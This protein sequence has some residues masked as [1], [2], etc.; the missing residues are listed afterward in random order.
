MTG[1]GVEGYGACPVHCLQGLF[2]FK[3]GRAIF[4][5]DRQ[6]AVALRA[7]LFH[8]RGIEHGTVRGSGEWEGGRIFP[9]FALRI[10]MFVFG[11][12]LGGKSARQAAKRD[13]VLGIERQTVAIPLIAKR[14]VGRGLHRFLIHDG[15]AAL[16]VLHD[17]VECAFAVRDAFFGHAAQIDLAR[18]SSRLS[19]DHRGVFGRVTEDVDAL[20]GSVE[21]DAVGLGA[22][23]VDR[24][25]QLQRLGVE[26][27]GGLAAGEAVSGFGIDHRSIAA[28]AGDL[29]N[30]REGIEVEHG[31]A[32][33][34]GMAA[35]APAGAAAPPAPREEY[36][37]A[38]RQRQRRCSPRCPR[39]RR[40]LS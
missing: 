12:S 18:R 39:R 9:S 32:V 17:D 5:D 37:Y 29:A 14:I 26:H 16:R 40:G 36:R 34:D 7:E 8:R 4:L 23:D 21:E 35:G 1:L 25:D 28:D 31:D 22:A 10:T 13:L 2:D 19:I 6:R 27:R 15:D 11:G 33:R 24:L 30:R 38:F 20:V 3:T